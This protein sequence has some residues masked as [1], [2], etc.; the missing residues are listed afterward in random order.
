M[1]SQRD[2][3]R[4]R[5]K[6][7]SSVKL[8]QGNREFTYRLKTDLVQTGM[9]IKWI[10][11]NW[12]LFKL[13]IYRQWNN[14]SDNVNRN[15][16]ETSFAGPLF[17]PVCLQNWVPLVQ[18][19]SNSLFFFFFSSQR[20]PHFVHMGRSVHKYNSVHT[21]RHPQWLS[22]ACEAVA[23]ASASAVKV[24]SGCC[25]PSKVL[26]TVIKMLTEKRHYG[27]LCLDLGG[28]GA[29]RVSFKV[30][31]DFECNFQWDINRDRKE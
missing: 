18:C 29:K 10:T 24:L 20:L 5:K 15:T 19:I 30:Q 17:P 31:S 26:G 16:C 27:H 1:A 8:E 23:A 7:C 13:D 22:C 11:Q 25:W 12:D 2:H 9:L 3:E 21:W 14:T 6:T 4:E 28:G